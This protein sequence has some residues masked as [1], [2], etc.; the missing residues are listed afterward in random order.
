MI[1]SQASKLFDNE[2]VTVADSLLCPAL[3]VCVCVQVSREC[4]WL[5][6]IREE[7]K[8]REKMIRPRKSKTN[9]VQ[10]S[11]KMRAPTPKDTHTNIKREEE[12]QPKHKTSFEWFKFLPFIVCTLFAGHHQTKMLGIPIATLSSQIFSC[13]APDTASQRLA[14]GPCWGICGVQRSPV[15]CAVG[16]AL[17]AH[18]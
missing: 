6:H 14:L 1:F 18:H 7:E 3:C 5:K 16:H 12:F 10:L 4:V 11:A 13:Q 15:V 9:L 2:M 8:E 17:S